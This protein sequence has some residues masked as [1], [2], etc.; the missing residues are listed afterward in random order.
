MG[1]LSNRVAALSPERLELLERRLAQR[2]AKEAD[3]RGEITEDVGLSLNGNSLTPGE[4]TQTTS[5]SQTQVL[6]RHDIGVSVETQG[7][8][9]QAQQE[10]ALLLA[11]LDELSD[12]TVDSLLKQILAQDDAPPPVAKGFPPDASGNL[13]GKKYPLVNAEELL[14][15]LDQFSEHEMN[16]LIA[17]L[18]AAEGN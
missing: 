13:T 12:E 1:D 9:G 5:E 18:L 6:H 15:N 14:E 8:T 11:G 10:A 4:P 17:E 3:G 16:L 2:R 7:G